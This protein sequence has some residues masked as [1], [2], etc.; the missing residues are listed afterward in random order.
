MPEHLEEGGRHKGRLGALFVEVTDGTRFS[1]GTGLSDAEREAPPPVGSVVTF[2][3]ELSDGGVPRF[4]CYVGVRGDAPWPSTTTPAPRTFAGAPAAIPTSPARHRFEQVQGSSSKFWEV[5]RDGC[6]VTA[7]FGRIGSERQA[8]TKEFA[9]EE[10]ARCH[11]EGLTAEKLAK[12]Y[13]EHGD[14]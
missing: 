1:V 13:R 7:R 6:A 4:P 11:A 9:S 2:R 8:K 3:Y 10:L 5:A 14:A 12:G